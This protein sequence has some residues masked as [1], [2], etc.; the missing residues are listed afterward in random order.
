MNALLC[1]SK[2]KLQFR[3]GR[4]TCLAIGRK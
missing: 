3:K 1:V 4:E 2:L